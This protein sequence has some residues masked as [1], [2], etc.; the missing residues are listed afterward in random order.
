NNPQRINNDWR[1]FGRLTQW[2]NKKDE[3]E[4]ERSASMIK[5]ASYTVQ[6]D[7]SKSRELTQ[8]DSHQ[9]RVF[10]YGYV[11]DFQILQQPLFQPNS[12]VDSLVNSMGE[13]YSLTGVQYQGMQDTLVTFRPGTV[14]PNA[15]RH[16]E[17][18]YELVGAQLVDGVYTSPGNGSQV[19]WY[20]NI[21]TIQGRL[22]LPNGIRPPNIYSMWYNT[23]RQYNYYGIDNDDQ[24][25][26]RAS[27]QFDVKKP[28]IAICSIFTAS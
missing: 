17:A 12:S 21:F 8:D 25:S 14:N 23:G 3:D 5:N 4:E 24:F 22:G 9:D 16:T 28:I 6:V 19:G 13:S 11:G 1:I 27:G 2:F 26:L 18:Y 7:Y 15:A 10:D 20:D